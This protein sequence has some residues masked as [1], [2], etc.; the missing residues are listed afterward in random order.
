MN[1]GEPQKITIITPQREPVPER[2]P[3]RR[4]EPVWLPEHQPER[5]PARV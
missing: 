2:E 5:E 1:I 3:A 4:E